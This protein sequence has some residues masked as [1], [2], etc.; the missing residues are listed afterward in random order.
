MQVPKFRKTFPYMIASCMAISFLLSSCGAKDKESV[1]PPNAIQ[2]TEQTNNSA[3]SSNESEA[4][5]PTESQPS[6]TT[7][8]EPE[9][10]VRALIA[11]LPDHHIEMFGLD[12]GVE[13]HVGDHV[14]QYDW[15]Y[16]TPRGIEPRMA[17]KDY[18]GDGHDELAIILYIGSGTGVSVEELHMIEIEEDPKLRDHMFQESDYLD[19]VYPAISFK[20]IKQEEEL[21][22]EVKVGSKTIEVT[23]KNYYDHEEFGAASDKLGI[24]DI[25]GFSFDDNKAIKASFGVGVLFEKIASPQYIGRLNADV[26]YRDGQF[27]L[28]NYEFVVEENI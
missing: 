3:A 18:D 17:V 8:D 15:I 12:N 24:R 23:M 10:P 9:I 27:K 7:E 5:A 1:P 28:S 25:V 19:Q 20:P 16:M 26:S 22:A 4:E 13:L 11:S 14:Q 6:G 2:Q 21:T